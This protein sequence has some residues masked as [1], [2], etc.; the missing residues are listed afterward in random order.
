MSRRRDRIAVYE[1]LSRIGKA[2]ASPARIELLDLL[3]Q[4]PRTVEALARLTG[5]SL[6]NVSQHLQILRRTNLVESDKRGLFVTY[7]LADDE[8]AE[9]MVAM[10]RTTESRLPDL[11]R[12]ARRYLGVS[13]GVDAE[14]REALIERVRRGV[15]T[16]VDVRPMEEFR[17]GHLP[18]AISM[19][20]DRLEHGTARLSKKK[21]IVAYCRGPYCAFAREAVAL[22]R[23][24]GHRAEILDE[25][26][27]EW[28]ARGLPVERA[29]AQES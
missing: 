10:R 22:L 6:A 7:R 23:A 20:I 24:R 26:V 8:V 29:G 25:G 11:E 18:G 5:Q 17:A 21:P 16:V 28:R 12:A 15:V 4:A 14:K 2:V 19:P 27:V 9:L 13:I 1:Q 3:A